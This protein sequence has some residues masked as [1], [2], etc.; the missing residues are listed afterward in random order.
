LQR[1]YQRAGHLGGHDHLVE[2]LWCAAHGSGNPAD[3]SKLLSEYLSSRRRELTQPEASLRSVTAS[4][5]AWERYCAP[6]PLIPS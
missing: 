3:A 5:S 4:D 1:T 2:A 6:A